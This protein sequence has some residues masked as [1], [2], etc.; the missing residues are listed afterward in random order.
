MATK[1]VDTAGREF[2]TPTRAEFDAAAVLLKAAGWLECGASMVDNAREAGVTD[3]GRLFI[4]AGERYW[5]NLKTID[6]APA[7]KCDHCGAV[8]A[9]WCEYDVKDRG[10]VRLCLTCDDD[11]AVMILQQ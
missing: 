9:D 3:F 7:A 4:R 8:A 6:G 5:L 10:R 1:F 2:R 11:P